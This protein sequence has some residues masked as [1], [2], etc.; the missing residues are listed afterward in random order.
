MARPK[1]VSVRPTTEA[2]LERW[3]RC[4]A[5]FPKLSFS[6]FPRRL[7]D[8]GVT[9]ELNARR[10][11]LVANER[12]RRLGELTPVEQRRRRRRGEDDYPELADDG[13]DPFLDER[14]EN[15]ARE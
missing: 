10:A 9:I 2:Q 12:F 4:A 7:I 14:T 13:L 11:D 3:R 15:E 8:D 5:Y 1:P 6:E